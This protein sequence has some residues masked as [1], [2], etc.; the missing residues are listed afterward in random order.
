MNLIYS[1]KEIVLS[2]KHA[3]VNLFFINCHFDQLSFRS[4]KPVPGVH[5]K[6]DDGNVVNGEKEK[7]GGQR[8]DF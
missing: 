6:K 7:E 4:N 8:Q 1:N 5:R 3:K 2:Q